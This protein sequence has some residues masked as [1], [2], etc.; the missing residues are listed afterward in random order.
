MEMK[1]YVLFMLLAIIISITK[2]NVVFGED[3]SKLGSPHIFSDVEGLKFNFDTQAE[4]DKYTK[5]L[6]RVF[7]SFNNCGDIKVRSEKGIKNI[8]LV[9]ADLDENNYSRSD[10]MMI[11]TVNSKKNTIKLTSIMRDTYVYIKGHGYEK[12]NHS[13][14]YGGIK[15]LK[16]TIENNFKVKIDNYAIVNFEG[17]ASIVEVFEG[18]ELEITDEEKAVIEKYY[19]EIARTEVGG[20]ILNGEQALYY[21]IY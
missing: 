20:Y 17:F 18:V 11:M 13:Y 16:H 10:T 3:Y 6:K 12:I 7:N 4:I 14:A 2:V 8:L 15:L 5:E 9:G 19:G 21:S 1:R